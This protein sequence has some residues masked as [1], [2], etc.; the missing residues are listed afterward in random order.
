MPR[1]LYDSI[2]AGRGLIPHGYT[3]DLFV[4]AFNLSERVKWVFELVDCLNKCWVVHR[5]YGFSDAELPEGAACYTSESGSEADF[6][7]DVMGQILQ[8]IDP[9]SRV[10][11]DSTGFMR[12][13][14]MFLLLYLKHAGFTQLDILYTE[15]SHYSKK[16]ET[17]FSSDVYEVRQVAGYEGNHSADLSKDVLLVGCGYD[18][19]LVSEVISYKSSARVLQ[20]LSL[21][22]LSADMY[23]E[24]LVR[25]QR[26]V[27]SPANVPDTQIAYVAANDPFAT[28]MAIEES[29]TRIAKSQNGVSNLYMS[30][31]ATKPQVLGFCLF[32]LKRLSGGPVSMIFPFSREYAKETSKGVGRVWLYKVNLV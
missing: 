31:L 4:S 8:G 27:D 16:S 9:K 12:P 22:S 11:I 32:Y 7:I 26:V 20:L 10:C 19:H 25:L 28:F 17:V 23:Q 2:G 24:S 29:V 3:C 6:I 18:H 14:L 1:E 30:P 13:H 21:P 15:P 5:E